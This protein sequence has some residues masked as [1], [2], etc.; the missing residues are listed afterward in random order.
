MLRIGITG[1]IGS[2][3]ST[4]AKIFKLLGIPVYYAD[5]EAKILMDKGDLKSQIMHIFGDDLYATG[6]LNRKKLAS[7]VFNEP[8]KLTQLNAIVHPA[9]IAGFDTWVMQQAA[10]YSIKE[11]ALIFE[12]ESYKHLDYVIGVQCPEAM[13]ITR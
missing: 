10:P 11:A 4:V 5:Q 3:K 12:S 7:I 2:G 1:G 8:E 13:R 9:T 6:T